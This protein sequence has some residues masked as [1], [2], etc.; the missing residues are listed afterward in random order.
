M[1]KKK[2]QQ[3]GLSVLNYCVRTRPWN[4]SSFMFMVC[5]GVDLPHPWPSRPQYNWSCH[6]MVD[7]LFTCLVSLLDLLNPLPPNPEKTKTALASS[8]PREGNLGIWISNL[9]IIIICLNVWL[10]PSP[11]WTITT[12]VQP[13]VPFFCSFL[14]YF[15]GPLLTGI[16]WIFTRTLKK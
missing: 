3:P 12:L 10:M 7:P 1:P 11:I 4:Q 16:K 5:S 15:S 9:H 6:I 8:Y 13:I 14:L 2:C